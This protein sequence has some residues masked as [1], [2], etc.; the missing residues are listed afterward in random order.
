MEAKRRRYQSDL[1]DRE[2][3]LIEPELP[4]AKTGGRPRTT[5]MRELLNSIFYI[6]KAG[7]QWRMMP[8]DLV[9]W[10][11]VYDYFR[12]WTKNGT[13]KK[14]NDALRVKVRVAEGRDPEPSAACIDSQS[15]KTTSKGGSAATTLIRKSKAERGTSSPT[16]LDCSSP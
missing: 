15:S 1:T 10:G 16:R 7:C 4:P 14:I 3:R 13:W 2:W 12:K 11:T 5:D 9:T 6:Q 8:N